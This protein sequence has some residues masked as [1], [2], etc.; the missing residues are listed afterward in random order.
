MAR[1]TVALAITLATI[2]AALS[3]APAAATDPPLPSSM[4]A[5]GDSI[6]QAASTVAVG[7]DSPQ[8]SW[9]TGTSATVSSHYLRLLALNPAITGRNDNRSVSGAKMFDL[10][11][12]MAAA[13]AGRPEYL[14]VLIGGN[15][16][17]TS[18][19]DAMTEVDVFR[20]QFVAAM[21]ALRAA[22][23]HTQVYVVSI[24]RVMGLYDLFKGNGW[25]RFI[26]SIG[27]V[28][29]S[30]LA[31]PTSTEPA[32]EERRI[33][34]AERNVHFNTVLADV[35]ALY[36][37]CRTDGGAVYATDFVA[38]DV[39]GDYFHPSTSGQAKLAAVSWSAGYWPNAV[40]PPPPPPQ[41]QPPTAAFGFSCTGLACSFTDQS[42][43]VGGTIAS[44]VWD[45][46]GG[47]TY[48]VPA[49][50]HTFGAAG[51]YPVRLTVIDNG[52]ASATIIRD[53]VVT[54]PVVQQMRVDRLT[55]TSA[56]KS[57][58][59]T[60]TVTISVR[61]TDGTPVSGAR[62]SATWTVGAADTCTTTTAG[63]CSVVSDSLPRSSVP[64]V[65]MTVA[66][67]THATLP[68]DQGGSQRQIT[69]NRPT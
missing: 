52:G 46:G 28:C 22:S 50:T 62:V 6:T 49:P 7:A 14:T 16:V 66:N 39:S 44:R 2:L 53:V 55:A 32:D 38:S 29:Q 30:L 21:N 3:V 24:P 25:A 68:W 69:V 11:G 54:Q 23:P 61:R 65:T 35:C 19:E 4:A 5:V 36:Q 10:A 26:W 64:S 20:D 8:N 1:R 56:R 18:T 27:N 17:C 63:T 43:D 40:P 48:T 57:S 42:T 37:P 15:D 13:G 34:V 12:Q 9:S 31:R 45:F 58:N 47:V 67:V 41:N 33:R 51:T 59:W 60:A